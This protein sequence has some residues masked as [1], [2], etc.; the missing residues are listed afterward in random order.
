M[1]YWRKFDKKIKKYFENLSF[2]VSHVILI[3][4]SEIN[5][6]ATVLA[7]TRKIAS[8]KISKNAFFRPQ[9]LSL[10]KNGTWLFYKEGK[11]LLKIT[12]EKNSLSHKFVK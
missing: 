6:F 7:W 5:Y 3:V 10:Q 2:L 4:H 11:K 9:I 8:F 12:S 1:K